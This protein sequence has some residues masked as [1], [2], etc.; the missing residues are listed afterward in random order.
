MITLFNTG[1]LTV[2]LVWMS[3]EVGSIYLGT[4][5]GSLRRK[6]II[7]ERVYLNVE[8]QGAPTLPQRFVEGYELHLWKEL[9]DLCSSFLSDNRQQ[10]PSTTFEELCYMAWTILQ[11]DSEDKGESKRFLFHYSKT[12]DSG[13]SDFMSSV[14]H[15][16]LQLVP[17]LH[18]RRMKK[19]RGDD[20]YQG[21]GLI[22]SRGYF[23]FR[24]RNGRSS[25]TFH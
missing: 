11:Q 22:P 23:L 4:F 10:Q 15:P 6:M 13:N 19:G 17:E 2:I 18:L 5:S 25:P 3:M 9:D 21:L 14:L 20:E 1:S 12:H 7:F 24:P 16:L 8:L